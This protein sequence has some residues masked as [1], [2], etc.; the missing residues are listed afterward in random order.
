MARQPYLCD[1]LL[2]FLCFVLQ[3]FLHDV[4]FDP[5]DGAGRVATLPER[6]SNVFFFLLSVVLFRHLSNT[7]VWKTVSKGYAITFT[8]PAFPTKGSIYIVSQKKL[9]PFS[10][11]NNFGKYC[12]I[13]ITLLLL[14][15]KMNYDQVYPKIYHSLT[16]SLLRLTS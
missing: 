3:R 1:C 4:L 7:H 8:S 16:H 2:Y 12:H 6:F 14:Q 15:T 11:E 9:D 5:I 13:L 10:F